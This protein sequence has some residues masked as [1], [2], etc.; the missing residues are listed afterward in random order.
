[1]KL[2]IVIPKEKPRA[3]VYRELI[4]MKRNGGAHEARKYSRKKKHKNRD[5]E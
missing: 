4:A 3:E 5:F 1:M 2:T